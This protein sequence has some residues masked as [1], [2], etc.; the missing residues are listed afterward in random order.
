MYWSLLTLLAARQD[1]QEKSVES[2]Q[3][4]ASKSSNQSLTTSQSK[5]KILLENIATSSKQRKST[6]KKSPTE[7]LKSS[8]QSK[9]A[10]KSTTERPVQVDSNFSESRSQKRKTEREER[11]RV[12][13]KSCELRSEKRRA[14]R[15]ETA[16]PRKI[17]I[18]VQQERKRELSD[19][20]SMSRSR[21]KETPKRL[22]Y[23]VAGH[24]R[25][26]SLVLSRSDLAYEDDGKKGAAD[27]DENELD[28]DRVQQLLRRASATKTALAKLRSPAQEEPES[29]NE[30]V[31]HVTF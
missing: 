13:R 22:K 2:A 9:P 23:S 16:T 10:T 26:K 7:T 12:D 19:P 27:Q 17:A 21:T 30:K 24:S 25:R 5:R 28:E 20:P 3:K 29:S 11:A 8:T 14:G 31:Q 1:E 6:Q 4:P 15:E 18:P